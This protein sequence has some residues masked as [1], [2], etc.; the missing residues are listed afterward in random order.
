MSDAMKP[1]IYAASEG[2]LSRAQAEAAFEELF[3]GTATPAQV[4]GL[5]MAMRARGESVAEYAA[6]AKVMRA[7]CVQVGARRARWTSSAPGA[8]AR[9][10]STS[11]PPRPSSSRAR[12]CRWPSTATATSVRNPA[13]RMRCTRLGVNVMVGPEVVERGL[14]GRDRLHDGADAPPGDETCHARPAGAGFEDDLQHPRAADQP[15]GRQA[16]ADR[17]LRDRPDLPHGRDAAG[18]GSEAAWLVHGSDGTDEIS[19][20]G[21]RRWPN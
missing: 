7:K 16:A 11:P 1:L 8:T 14:G 10:R 21:P 4:G 6:A 3:E 18:A 9:G 20:S 17:G 15:R 13:R 5:L 12:A 2:P 19:I